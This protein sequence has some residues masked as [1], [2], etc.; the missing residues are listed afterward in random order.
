MTEPTSAATTWHA[1]PALLRQYAAGRLDP[2]AQAA[3]ET[4][5]E[6]CAD[7]RAGAR[8]LVAPVEL[9]ATW[10]R[11]LVEVRTPEPAWPIRALRRSGLPEV[12]LVVLRASTNLLVALGAAAAGA[13]AFALVAARLSA[14]RQELAWLAVAPLLPALLVAGAYDSTDPLR[15]LA[16]PTPYSKL[17]VAL[18]R[19]AVSVAG[20]LPLV[21]LMSLVPNIDA[22]VATWL[23]PALAIALVLLVL[24]TRWTAVVSVG[25]VSAAWLSAVGLLRNGD[26]L[27]SVTQPLGQASCLLVAVGSALVLLR[28]VGGLRPA[29]E[30]S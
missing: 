3:V 16:E 21:L 2:I 22:S 20:A 17:R 18:L 12:D 9:E 6:R 1:E 13:L 26:A 19:T 5:V 29:T 23:L 24:L 4:H 15:E 30:E 25:V 27:D 14:D 8:A 7:C 10:E 11:V 28:E